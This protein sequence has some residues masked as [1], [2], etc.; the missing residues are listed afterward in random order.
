MEA[1]SPP[2]AS[3]AGRVER[4]ILRLRRDRTVEII[5]KQPEQRTVEYCGPLVESPEVP[6][7][8]YCQDC[9]VFLRGMDYQ[10]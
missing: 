7:L 2:T 6:R 3:Y 8:A 5:L 9:A 1:C 10:Q 4:G